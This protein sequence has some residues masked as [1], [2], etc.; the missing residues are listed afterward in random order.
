[1]CARADINHFGDINEMVTN[2]MAA[3]CASFTRFRYDGD[4]IAEVGVFQYPRQ[5]TSGPK[6]ATA[7]IGALDTLERVARGGNWS[8]VAHLFRALS[9]SAKANRFKTIV[10]AG[11][12]KSFAREVLSP[13][14]WQI[15]RF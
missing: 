13:W 3:L 9:A 12:C 11:Q 1:L 2:R 14:C 10:R 5:F 15:L 7:F 8:L 4:E 6:L